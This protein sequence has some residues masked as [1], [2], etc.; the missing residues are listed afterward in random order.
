[1]SCGILEPDA[2]N[3]TLAAERLRAGGLVAMPTETVYGL[4][5]N[6]LDDRAVASIYATK[7]RPQFNPLIVHLPTKEDAAR[8]AVITPLAQQLMDTYWPGPCTLVLQRAQDCPLSLLVSA[9]LDT[10]ALRMPAHPVAQALLKEAKL[11]LAAPSANR[12]GRVSPT[13]PAHVEAEFK[14]SAAEVLILNGGACAVGVEST[15]IDARGHAPVILRHGSITHEMLAQKFGPVE[16][17]LKDSPLHSPGM[18]ASHYAPNAALRM[19]VQ[20]ADAGEALLAFGPDAPT[21]KN[22]K[23]LSATGDLTEASAN[24]F[25]YLRELDDT[26]YARIAVMPIPDRGL[27]VAIND[28]LKRAST[29]RG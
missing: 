20:H 24:L 29:P 25:A 11:P 16:E 6:A 26:G 1:M 13:L 7:E 15:V 28:R 5:A 17:A 19:N 3:I 23:N 2:R 8:Y 4:A 21:G 14:N 22:V 18:L 9:G 12:S 27:G 10:V